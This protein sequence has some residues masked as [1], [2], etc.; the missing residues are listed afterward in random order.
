[1]RK[2]IEMC[3]NCYGTHYTEAE[4]LKCE[5]AQQQR[6]SFPSPIGRGKRFADT[7]KWCGSVHLTSA[8]RA[9]CQLD[10]T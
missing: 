4:R 8:A 10:N 2:V 1:M 5:Q 9:Q 6:D 7:C 3:Q